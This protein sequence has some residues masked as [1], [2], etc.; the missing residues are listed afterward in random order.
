MSFNF[1][2]NFHNIEIDHKVQIPTFFRKIN[3]LRQT[4]VSL[5]LN[6]IEI[7]KI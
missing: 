6:F 2:S 4:H 3:S 5:D 1:C 7:S